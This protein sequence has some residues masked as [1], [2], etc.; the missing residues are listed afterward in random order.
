VDVLTNPVW[1]A[2]GGAQAAFAE[3]K[4]R[5]RRFRTD[6]S[7]FAG[8]PDTP[9]ADD[10]DSLRTLVGPGGTAF[11][12]RE[13]IEIPEGWDATFSLTAVQMTFERASESVAIGATQLT[14]ADVP[15]MLDLVQ[16]TQPGP[17]LPATLELG[18]YLGV[19][20]DGALVAMAGE[21]LRPPGY[22]EVSAVCTDPAFRGRGLAA[23]LTHAVMAGI[24]ARGDRP[25]LHAAADNT[26]AIRLYERLGFRHNRDV[27]GVGVR[28]PS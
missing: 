16:R 6:V 18:R 1:H 5:A 27:S 11:L 4:G 13:G 14:R 28:A 26:R 25:I 20:I 8:L 12:M 15:A 21:R 24:T 9:D 17:F 23:S 22:T 10:W 7:P 3:S 19:R 2:L